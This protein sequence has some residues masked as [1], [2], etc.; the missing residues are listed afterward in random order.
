M[1]PHAA[2]RFTPQLFLGLA[3]L[4]TGVVFLLHNLGVIDLR[5][6]LSC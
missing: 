3:V 5:Q 2:P 4:V 1:R 6:Y